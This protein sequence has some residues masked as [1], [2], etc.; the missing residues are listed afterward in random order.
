MSTNTQWEE[1]F[2]PQRNH[3]DDFNN[4]QDDNFPRERN[5]DVAHTAD[6]PFVPF[7]TEQ[8]RILTLCSVRFMHCSIF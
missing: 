5:R 3:G 8:Y 2:P 1:C 6:W 7:F 4:Q